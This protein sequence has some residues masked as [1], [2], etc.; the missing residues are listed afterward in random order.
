MFPGLRQR[1]DAALDLIVEFSTL[2]EYRLAVDAA[3]GRASAPHAASGRVPRLGGA[4]GDAARAAD[5]HEVAGGAVVSTRAPVARV[6]LRG[7]AAT[8]AAR[9]LVSA[10]CGS[11]TPRRAA[12][13]VRVGAPGAPEQLC[14]AV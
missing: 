11:P 14:L 12:A 4:G 7:A 5:R 3:G 13:R 2:G 6:P 9:R 10:A 1:L 8:P